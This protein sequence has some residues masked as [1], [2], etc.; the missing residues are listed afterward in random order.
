VFNDLQQPLTYCSVLSGWLML[1][2]AAAGNWETLRFLLSNARWWM[3]EYKFDGYRCGQLAVLAFFRSAGPI[4]SCPEYASSPMANP[5]PVNYV[6]V[7]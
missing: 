7:L 6:V 2:A 4:T 5:T 1:S 3:D